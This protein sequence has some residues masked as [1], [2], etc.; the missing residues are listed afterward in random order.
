METLVSLMSP[1]WALMKIPLG[2][3]PLEKILSTGQLGFFPCIDLTNPGMNLTLYIRSKTNAGRAQHELIIF[4]KKQ[5][6]RILNLRRDHHPRQWAR[7]LFP[8]KIYT[9]GCWFF[10]QDT[11]DP[12]VWRIRDT[13]IPL[14]TLEHL[15]TLGTFQRLRTNKLS[16][17]CKG[18]ALNTKTLPIDITK[19]RHLLWRFIS[20]VPSQQSTFPKKI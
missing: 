1:H 18:I 8:I 12:L 19:P 14:Q 3:W 10:N 9:K 6:F 17:L 5:I 11:P 7:I 13:L 20:F 15:F 4:R 2:I 16:L